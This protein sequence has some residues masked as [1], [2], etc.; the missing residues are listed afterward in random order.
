MSDRV[1]PPGPVAAPPQGP[2]WDLPIAEAPLAFI[3][4]EMTGLDV[5]VD[6]VIEVAV[7]RVVGGAL[8]GRLSSL[9]RPD[10]GR[11]GNAHV[12]GIS[13]ADLV[14]APTFAEI[15]GDLLTIVDGAAL[16]AHGSTLDRAFLD[17]ELARAGRDVRVGPFIDTLLLARRTFAAPS[18]AL[19]A[20]AKRLG[21]PAPARSHRALD[22]VQTMRGVYEKC[23]SLLAPAT[24]R[25]LLQVRIGEGLARDLVLA[26][27][28]E[29]RAAGVVVRVTYRAPKRQAEELDFVITEVRAKLD[30]PVL[31]GYLHR[32]RS[33]RELR[34]DRVLA[35]S[36]SS[37]R[38]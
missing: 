20:I 5:T 15:A 24:P 37:P 8:V 10:D 35:I 36:R 31:L 13:E 29:A 34:A 21:V 7:E 6:R 3:D 25:D 23:A 19:A 9:V 27:A 12:H 30:P 11:F 17:A 26:R 4:L 28:E 14:S 22:D 32:C 33:R 2:P 1:E 38:P 18:H 16:V